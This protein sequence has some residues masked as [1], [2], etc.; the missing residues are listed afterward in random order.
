MKPFIAKSRK[1]ALLAKI[2]PYCAESLKKWAK[3]RGFQD[4][5]LDQVIGLKSNRISEIKA[6]NLSEPSLIKLIEGGIVGYSALEQNHDL[7]PTEKEYLRGFSLS[8]NGYKW[9]RLIAEARDFG[10]EEEAEA[11]IKALIN[12]K[13]KTSK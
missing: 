1:M 9:G 2:A 12:K 10:L 6:G 7:T 4:I 13:K 5:E 11:V 3:E 8:E